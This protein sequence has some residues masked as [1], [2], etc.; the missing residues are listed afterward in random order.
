[1]PGRYP[2][3]ATTTTTTHLHFFFGGV[4]IATD[5]DLIFGYSDSEFDSLTQTRLTRSVQCRRLHLEADRTA[6]VNG[7]HLRTIRARNNDGQRAGK[8]LT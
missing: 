8:L 1:M 5:L 4:S 2:A 7:S 6:V 3:Q